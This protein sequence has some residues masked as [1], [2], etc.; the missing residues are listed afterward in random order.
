[1]CIFCNFLLVHFF[2]IFVRG[3]HQEN[4]LVCAMYV[5]VGYVH[6]AVVRWRVN[7]HVFS[8]PEGLLAV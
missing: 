3:I 7:V 4:S 8:N 1:V 2:A 6:Q 5:Y